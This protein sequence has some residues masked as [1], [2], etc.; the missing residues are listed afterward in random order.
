MPYTNISQS[1]PRVKGAKVTGATQYR[2]YSAPRHSVGRAHG[3]GTRVVRMDIAGTTGA[4][5]MSS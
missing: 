1:T 3:L 2:G 5:V 4:G